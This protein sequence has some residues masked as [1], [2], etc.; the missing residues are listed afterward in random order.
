[1]KRRS[2]AALLAVSLLAIACNAFAA[3]PVRV[4][5][6]WGMRRLYQSHRG[7]FDFLAE[8]TERKS[9][10]FRIGTQAIGQYFLTGNGKWKPNY[11]KA[12]VKPATNALVDVLSAEGIKQ[13][14]YDMCMALLKAVG[15][16]R[17]DVSRHVD[18]HVNQSGRATMFPRWARGFQYRQDLDTEDFERG[19]EVSGKILAHIDGHWYMSKYRLKASFIPH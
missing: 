17:V 19:K 2:S 12:S 4:R 18:I 16:E 10:T 1:M 3:E 5:T 6:D 13:K 11:G 14:Q 15:Q 8:L 9:G 7:A